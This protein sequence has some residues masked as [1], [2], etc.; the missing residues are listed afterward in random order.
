MLRRFRAA[1]RAAL[2]ALL[3]LAPALQACRNGG[4]GPPTPDYTL[5]I[6]AGNEQT[7]QSGSRVGVALQVTVTNT[8]TDLVPGVVVQF[9][10]LPGSDAVLDDTV[11]V[12]GF[13]G[14]ASTG[15]R[16]GGYPDTA[17]VRA[18]VEGQEDGAVVFSIVATPPPVITAVTPTAFEAGDTIEVT[19]RYFSPELAA[20]EVLVGNA[21]GRILGLTGD[22]V[23]QVVVPACATGG[24]DTLTVRIG[25]ATATFA[26]LSYAAGS[27]TPLHAPLQGVVLSG[28]ELGDC[29]RLP[30]DGARY[31]LVPQLASG[32]DTVQS[33]SYTVTASAAAALSAAMAEG[34]VNDAAE[35]NRAQHAFD[36]RMRRLEQQ[37]APQTAREAA[38]IRAEGATRLEA[39]EVG[40]KRT[41]QVLSSL[42]GSVS[43]RE[44]TA[45]LKYIGPKTLLYYDQAAPG[46]SAGGFSDAQ[47]QQFGKLFDETLHEIGVRNFGS[48]SDID[49]NGRV[50][51][52]MSSVVN[53]LTQRDCSRGS[54]IGFFYP[55]DFTR[56][57]GSNRGE[58]LY[59]LVPDPTGQF[60]CA[61][62][63]NEVQS[64]TPSTMLHEFQHMISHN[65]HVLVRRGASENVWLNEGLS[66]LA[67]EIGSRHYE[68]RCPPPACRSNGAIQLFPDSSQ[69]FI[70]N[71]LQNA[72]SYLNLPTANSVTTFRDFGSLAE[73]GGAWL[74]VR[75]LVDQKGE[76][77]I[78]RLVQTSRTSI[79]NVE[80]AAGESFPSLFGDFG[81]ATYTDSLPGVPRSAIPRRFRFETR[82]LRQ[83]FQRL[84]ATGRVASPFPI[85]TRVVPPAGS[86]S[87]TIVQGSMDFLTLQTD[88]GSGGTSLRY[89][90]SGGGTFPAGLRG[91]IGIF[92]LP[93]P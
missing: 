54:V 61:H 13:G 34:A 10:V 57:R 85:R 36:M 7:A 68:D 5:S 67:E 59:T 24:V 70:L 12:S 20:N 90:P 19:G 3:A 50:I 2:P 80:F 33:A 48:E 21:R 1:R 86:I 53:A 41:F 29:L 81:I 74:F 91:Q 17:H 84:N 30:G 4:D 55:N 32:S 47:L 22:S 49:N 14:I 71:L 51:V 23:M 78:P 25:T 52:L 43:F 69:G 42:A 35:G 31:L 58:I 83:I 65:Q 45:V 46:G 37:L 56:N 89:A 62:S 16:M 88:L 38:D 39:L 82:N 75:W 64:V 6:R 72:Y 60:D 87:G 77:I 73:R 15:L 93:N 66:I 76:Q 63:L 18:F 92:R 44:N 11:A 26:G 79:A 9:R 40:S 28:T 27:F 8:A